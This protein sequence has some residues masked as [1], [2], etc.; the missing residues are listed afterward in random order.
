MNR[1]VPVLMAGLLVTGC[2]SSPPTHFFALTPVPPNSFTAAPVS[3]PVKLGSVSIP[4][5]LDRESIVRGEAHNEVHISP[6]DRWGADLGEMVR[7]VLTEDLE[8]RLPPGMLL[9]PKTPA[10]EDARGIAVT[11]LSFEPVGSGSVALN[12]NWTL[13]EGSPPRVVLLRTVRLNAPGGL[14]A[15]SQA[16]AMSELLGQLADRIAQGLSETVSARAPATES[17]TARHPPH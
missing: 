6:Q 3:A 16:A 11:I 9:P 7:H 10:P 4:P 15:S 8:Q 2:G 17:G 13:L 1:T 5:L 12:A 14:T